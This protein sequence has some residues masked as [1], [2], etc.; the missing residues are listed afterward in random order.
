[1]ST[2][3]VVFFYVQEKAVGRKYPWQPVEFAVSKSEWCGRR[4]VAAGIPEYDF[5][6]RIWKKEVFYKKIRTELLQKIEI[7]F[8]E[9]TCFL[10]HKSMKETQ[11]GRMLETIFPMEL[12]TIPGKKGIVQITPEDVVMS[13]LEEYCKYDALVILDGTA[14]GEEPLH[15]DAKEWQENVARRMDL[16]EFIRKNC[17]RVNYLAVVTTDIERYVEVFEE[18]SEE[19]GLTGIFLSELKQAKPPAKYQTLVLDAGINDKR[20]WRE[21]PLCCIY[22]DLVSCTERQRIIEARRKDVRYISF[23]R[24]IEKKLKQKIQFLGIHP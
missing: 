10:Y 24:Q 9:T 14:D 16:T 22:L 7:E 8:W 17:N 12:I 6:K 21:L 19:Y 11:I 23:Y 4:L 15:A 2:E 13:L 18:M 5:N 3:A 1:M 20:T